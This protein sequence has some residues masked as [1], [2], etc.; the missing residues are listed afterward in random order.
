MILAMNFPCASDM[1]KDGFL[2]KYS[3]TGVGLW[4]ENEFSELKC[5]RLNSDTMCSIE[6]QTWSLQQIDSILNAAS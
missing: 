3:T 4:L 1:L 5:S 2:V 6:K